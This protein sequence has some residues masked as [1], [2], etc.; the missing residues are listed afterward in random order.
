MTGVKSNVSFDDK[1]DELEEKYDAISVFPSRALDAHIETWKNSLVALLVSELPQLTDDK[2]RKLIH[3]AEMS[4][5]VAYGDAT[6]IGV[7][8]EYIDVIEIYSK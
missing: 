7:I 6:L 5:A 2:A 1:L 3:R 8:R 4:S